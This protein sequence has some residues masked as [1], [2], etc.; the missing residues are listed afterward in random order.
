MEQLFL[1][2]YE[3]TVRQSYESE[4]GTRE[5]MTGVDPENQKWR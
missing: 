2:I 3:D 4:V 1:T 5:T